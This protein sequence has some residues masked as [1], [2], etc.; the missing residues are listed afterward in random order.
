MLQS[1]DRVSIAAS[2]DSDIYNSPQ[3]QANVEFKR[4]LSNNTAG[5]PDRA[6]D[7]FASMNNPGNSGNGAIN[8][9]NSPPT[10]PNFQ[11]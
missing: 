7:I 2:N 8:D 10:P 3:E 5:G 6:V 9:D 11:D 1:Y 4:S